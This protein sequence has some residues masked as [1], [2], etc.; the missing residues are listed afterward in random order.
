MVQTDVIQKAQDKAQLLQKLWI[1]ECR[2]VFNDR[3]ISS[4]DR[5]LL[6]DLMRHVIMDAKEEFID[7][8]LL[9]NEP[10]SIIFCNF[11]EME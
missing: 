8:T 7:L 11:A 4:E 9:D 1:H 5:L 10:S 3:L 6:E 2:R